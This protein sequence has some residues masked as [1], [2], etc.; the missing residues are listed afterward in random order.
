MVLSQSSRLESGIGSLVKP[1][2]AA[3]QKLA[4]GILSVTIA[5]A[6]C[7]LKHCSIESSSSEK[8][9]GVVSDWPLLPWRKLKYEQV[10]TDP[11]GQSEDGKNDGGTARRVRRDPAYTRDDIRYSENT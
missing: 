5:I 1:T 4:L 6:V 11:K 10:L 8:K 7:I 2:T 9:D 3:S